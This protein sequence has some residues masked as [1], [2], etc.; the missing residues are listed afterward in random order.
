MRFV[1][2][3]SLSV[4]AAAAPL[5][6][7]ITLDPS[8][9]PH[10][11]SGR[12]L[13]FLADAKRPRDVLSGGFVPGETWIAAKE[14]EFFAAGSTINF[15]ADNIAYPKPFSQAAAGD[16]EFMALLDPDHSY[17]RNA[18]DGG[19]LYSA[20]VTVRGINPADTAPVK[21]TITKL[22]PM[23]PQ[24]VDTDNVKLVEFV[25][26]ML[27]K[28]WGR[29]ITMRAGVVLPPDYAAS[30]QKKYPT[31]YDIHGF[32]GDHTQAWRVGPS[33]TKEIAD[34]KRFPMVHVYLDASFP[35]GHHVFADSVNN[36]PWGR[37][38]TEELIPH[39]EKRFRLIPKPS[40]RFLTGH[41]S[42]G[43][44][45]MWLE[46]NYPEVFGGTWSTSP[47]PVDLH[48]FTGVDV[49]PGSIQ[50]MYKN[51]A[52]GPLNLVRMN[53]KEIASF[54]QFARAEEVQGEYG[55][56]IASF[57]W[58]W[59]PKGPG[60]RPMKMFNRE[61]GEQDPFVQQAW[62]KYDI[63]KIVEKNWPTLGPKLLGKVHLVV[64]SED[65]FH[66]EEAAIMFC[67]FLKSKGREDVC[68]VVP[69]RDHMNLYQKYTTYPD[70][71]SLRIDHEMKASFEKS[72]K[73]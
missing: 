42:G 38:L 21:L 65:T 50:N 49:T 58:V 11:S 34:G 8:I 47:D 70:G 52:G 69:G 48:S 12:L 51:K 31:V 68:E 67:D 44:S 36:G 55:G 46:V 33:I 26:P 37:A 22:T 59:S 61:T 29:P 5:R 23:R 57:E 40:A 43:W 64:G 17:A 28:F 19:D 72:Q 10:G 9:A 4:F 20:V 6:F 63:R 18:Q 66:L 54:E 60:G 3:L 16:Y 73:R 41:S 25:S 71:L 15:D 32:G 35:T 13:V 53:G 1:L 39:L 14:V 7:E 27:S 45:T 56:Q 30:G 24:P 2:A 62:E